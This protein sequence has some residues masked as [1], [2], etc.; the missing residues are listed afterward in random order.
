MRRTWT[1][2]L[3]KQFHRAQEAAIKGGAKLS[4]MFL[5]EKLVE[6]IVF[7]HKCSDEHCR[8]MSALL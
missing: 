6:V 5:Q 1:Q 4:S 3:N 2:H 7:V 8:N